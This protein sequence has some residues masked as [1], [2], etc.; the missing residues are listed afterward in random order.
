MIHIKVSGSRKE[1]ISKSCINCT[2]M[3]VAFH[4]ALFC[5]CL[6]RIGIILGLQDPMK[7]KTRNKYKV[8]N[9]QSWYH[10]KNSV[11]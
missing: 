9:M 1:S 5:I 10:Y 11:Q 6:C 4:V 7:C 8:I 3:S 2:E